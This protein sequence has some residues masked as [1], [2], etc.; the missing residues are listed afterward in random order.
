[1]FYSRG[2]AYE[3]AGNWQKAEADLQKALE[4]APGQPSVLNYLGYTWADMGR[5]LPEA[6]AMI[7]SAAEQRK[8]DGA[9]TDS[10]GWVLYR[11]GE[12]KAAVKTLERAVELEPEDPTISDHLG[13]VYF[14]AGRKLEAMYEWKRALTLKPTPEDTAKIETKLR[15][16][17]P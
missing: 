7:Q 3:R 8:N 6:R 16:G 5:N 2:I 13:D 11:Q 10:L 17:H 9:I 1:M 12:I 4:L 15:N 14:A